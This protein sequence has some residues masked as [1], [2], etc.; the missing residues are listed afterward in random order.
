[1]TRNPNG[2]PGQRFSTHGTTAGRHLLP[3]PPKCCHFP[4]GRPGVSDSVRPLL[5]EDVHTREV[6]GHEKTRGGGRETRCDSKSRKVMSRTGE[7]RGSRGGPLPRHREGCT[8]ETRGAQAD[9]GPASPSDSATKH[10][11][12]RS[13]AQLTTALLRLRSAGVATGYVQK[14]L[15][16]HALRGKE[17]ALHSLLVT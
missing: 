11:A 12:G 5:K 14:R 1:M 13:A 7:L 2:S 16:G 3:E 15:L 10:L 17:H 8:R 9:P 4:K 6:C